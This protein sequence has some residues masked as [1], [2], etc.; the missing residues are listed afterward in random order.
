MKLTVALPGLLT[1]FAL[2]A[3]GDSDESPGHAGASTQPPAGVEQGAN[4]AVLASVRLDDGRTVV[5]HSFE[6]AGAETGPCLSLNGIDQ[7]KRA[8]G[9]AP[10]EV[11]PPLT[12]PVIAQATAQTKPSAPLEVYGATSA[13]AS[14]VVL[15]FKLGEST[16]E[17][18]AVLM[19]IEDQAVLDEA[20]IR[21]PFGYFLAELPPEAS[22]IRATAFDAEHAT[23][24]VDTFENFTDQ[25][26]HA[27]IS[28][29]S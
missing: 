14:E 12:D 28:G 20:G 17:L 10:S 24:G 18:P 5:L 11:E 6:P 3:C 19:V 25:H 16:R 23:V 21:E 8:C 27:F 22:H 9:R 13:E 7:N 2:A 15:R 4:S 1:M 29:A 26:P